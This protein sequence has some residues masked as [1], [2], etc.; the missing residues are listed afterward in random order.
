[1]AAAHAVSFVGCSDDDVAV[2]EGIGV[3]ST[4]VTVGDSVDTVRVKVFF[5]L[6]VQLHR[7]IMI[8]MKSRGVS[9]RWTLIKPCKNQEDQR[10]IYSTRKIT[11]PV[12]WLRRT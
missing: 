3:V 7:A 9:K 11:L 1:M 8:A 6:G 10:P 12:F 2:T 5:V 4:R